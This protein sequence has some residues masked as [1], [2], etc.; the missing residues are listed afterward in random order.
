MLVTAGRICSPLLLLE[1]PKIPWFVVCLLLLLLLS[2]LKQSYC[3]CEQ[4]SWV[5]RFFGTHELDESELA[6]G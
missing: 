1:C 5:S 2:L 3:P 6:L 4:E